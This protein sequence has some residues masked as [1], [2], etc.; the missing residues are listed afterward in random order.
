MTDL[1]ITATSVVAG[2][3]AQKS[4]GLLGEAIIAGQTVYMDSTLRKFM[5]ADSNSATVEARHA[6]HIA[7]N[8]GSLNQPITAQKG[9]DITMTTTPPLTV[10]LAYYQS[11]T[12]GGICPVAD[13]GSGEWVTLVGIA[14]STTV[15]Q[16]SFQFPGVAL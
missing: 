6:T 16:L 11:D 4:T 5:R 15:L 13:V 9:G 1:V 2:A 10:G 7:L 8:G 14:K 3:N 12:P